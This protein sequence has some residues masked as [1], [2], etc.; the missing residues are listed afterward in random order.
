MTKQELEEAVMK[1]MAENEA[2]KKGQVQSGQAKAKVTRTIKR[3][4]NGGVYVMDT[5][6]KAYSEKKGKEYT[7]GINI[8]GYQLQAF[9]AMLQDKSIVADV[10]KVLET[11]ETIQRTA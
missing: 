5:K 9:K 6:M 7:C 4:A 10:L 2:L 11:G 3:N 8:H 1:L